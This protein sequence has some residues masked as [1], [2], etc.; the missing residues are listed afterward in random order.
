MHTAVASFLGFYGF[1]WYWFYVRIFRDYEVKQR[2][3]QFFFSLV[4]ALT[5]HLFLLIV[6]EILDVL[7]RDMRWHN[8]RLD[9]VVML[10]VLVLV[11]P[12]QLARTWLRLYF[13]CVCHCDHYIH[14]EFFVSKV[15]FNSGRRNEHKIWASTALVISIFWYMFWKIGENIPIVTCLSQ[16]QDCKL[17]MNQFAARVGVIGVTIMAI[18]SGFG[19]INTPYT[20]MNVF[21][22]YSVTDHSDLMTKHE[23]D[24]VSHPKVGMHF[25]FLCHHQEVRHARSAAIHTSNVL[26]ARQNIRQKAPTGVCSTG[27]PHSFMIQSSPLTIQTN[28]FCF[29]DFHQA[30]GAFK[31]DLSSIPSTSSSSLSSSSSH[32]SRRSPWLNL[33][34]TCFSPVTTTLSFV[35]RLFFFCCFRTKVADLVVAN[36]AT[37]KLVSQRANSNQSLVNTNT[38]KENVHIHGPGTGTGAGGMPANM[39]S[40]SSG[41]ASADS[42]AHTRW[43]EAQ[44]TVQQLQDELAR[45]EQVFAFQNRVIQPGVFLPCRPRVLDKILKINFLFFRDN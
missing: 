16:N 33:L 4:F 17:S 43:L 44:A 13:R 27:K 24:S 18:L 15:Q 32:H 41:G 9:M 38:K 40:A 36:Q 6:F 3:V 14:S 30:Q 7:P 19:A 22:R 25:A 26:H 39:A 28:Y 1:A 37:S 2:S 23:M 8:W 20:Y 34:R 42:E 31:P 12:I 35:L 21:H 11:L 29:C 10:I 5:C 45:L